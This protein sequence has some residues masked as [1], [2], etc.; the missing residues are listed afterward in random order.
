MRAERVDAVL[1]VVTK[2]IRLPVEYQLKRESIGKSFFSLLQK[3]ALVISLFSPS[4]FHLCLWRP[5]VPREH[6]TQMTRRDAC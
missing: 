3:F 2:L 6:P 1:P 4:T 5:E